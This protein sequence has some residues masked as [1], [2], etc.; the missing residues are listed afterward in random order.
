MLRNTRLILSA[1][2]MAALIAA[3][4]TTS[5]MARHSQGTSWPLAE[6]AY[7]CTATGARSTYTQSCH[8]NGAGDL[9]GSGHRD[10]WGHWG[11]YYGPMVR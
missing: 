5:A 6:R 10:V 8:R 9:H 4:L 7:A 3:G 1:S 2:A 11:T